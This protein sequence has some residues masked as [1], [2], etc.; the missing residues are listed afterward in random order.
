[1]TT[2][3]TTA[4]LAIPGPVRGKAIAYGATGWLA[5]LPDLIADLEREWSITLGHV[6]PDS[7]EAL[8]AEATQ[9]DGTPAVLK[10]CVPR[11][12]DAARYE[13]TAL[14]LI[15]GE[16]C[17]SL[18]RADE[19]RG[20]LLIERLGRSMN[21]FGL[22]IEQ[23]HDLLCSA[24]QRVWRP[25]PDA[26]LPTA[27]EKGQWLID[28]ITA[29][30][31]DLDRPCSERAVEHAITCAR[32]RIAA[33]DDERAVLVHGDVHEWNALESRAD[34]AHEADGA[35]GAEF[36]LV[37]PDGL[38]AEAEYDLAVIMR[39]DPVELMEGDPRD[40]A[41]WLARRCGGLNATAIWEWGVVERV[42][43]GLGATQIGLQPLGRQLLTAADHIAANHPD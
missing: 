1:M 34:G 17:P 29:T 6:F 5:A 38:L 35:D 8:V 14:R 27:A 25:A 12:F 4:D 18:L 40:R 41:N 20:A 21:K 24:A 19:T 36:K 7:T 10:V 22:P 13:I 37:D 32:R 2:D 39:E 33:H 31:S 9:A 26:G 16:G 11:P 23:R 3:P 28:F 30:W 42:S 15:N 43:T